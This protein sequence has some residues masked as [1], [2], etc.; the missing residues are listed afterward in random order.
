MSWQKCLDAKIEPFQLT[1]LDLC[2]YWAARGVIQFVSSGTHV[3]EEAPPRTQYVSTST[4]SFR[5]L[6]PRYPP[7]PP[8]KG[9]V[10]DAVTK[11]SVSRREIC[12]FFFVRQFHPLIMISA[13]AKGHCK[14]SSG[15]SLWIGLLVVLATYILQSI[16]FACLLD[17]LRLATR[18]QIKLQS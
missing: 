11:T 15:Y 5:N 10:K 3:W 8:S 12:T 9:V 1:L 18:E 6:P 13:K 17:A 14:Q 16:C 7:N 2:R 4:A